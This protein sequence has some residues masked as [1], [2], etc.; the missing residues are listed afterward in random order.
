VTSLAVGEQHSCAVVGNG[1]L[2]C[3]G[4]NHDGQLGPAGA[5]VLKISKPALALANAEMVAAGDDFTC[6]TVARSMTCFGENLYGQ[7]GRGESSPSSDVPAGITG[8]IAATLQWNQIAARGDFVCGLSSTFELWC[9]GDNVS[10]AKKSATALEVAPGTKWM[11]VA[12]GATHTCGVTNN[13]V[14]QCWGANVYGQLGTGDQ[15][16]HPSPTTIAADFR[17]AGLGKN[18]SCAVNGKGELY[19]WGDNAAGQL[20]LGDLTARLVPT[21]VE[22]GMGWKQVSISATFACG[23]QTDDSLWCWGGK[24]DDDAPTGKLAPKPISFPGRWLQVH[25][26]DDHGCALRADGVVACWGRNTDGELGLGD[27][28]KRTTFVPLC[29]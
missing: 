21:K 18:S 11:D 2:W 20:G 24:G 29:P 23:I 17:S 26:H 22:L 9:W 19:C 8:A 3:W 16:E 14:L 6:A 12:A 13:G 25:L 28:T 10:S 27:G 1:G 4:R 7:L 15:K 5:G